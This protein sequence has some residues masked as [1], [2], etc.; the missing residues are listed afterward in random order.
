MRKAQR[1]E[2]LLLLLLELVEQAVSSIFRLVLRCRSRQTLSL[3]PSINQ[4][5]LHLKALISWRLSLVVEE[6]LVEKLDVELDLR[7]QLFHL[8]VF[9]RIEVTS[10]VDIK[11][12]I[13]ILSRQL[14]DIFFLH[15]L[16]RSF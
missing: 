9:E 8:V 12:I 14:R 1:L 7:G 2:C 11:L 3:C 15:R 6:D 13:L 4:P 5:T 16:L 10:E